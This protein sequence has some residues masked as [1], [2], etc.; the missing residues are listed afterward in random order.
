MS[1]SLAPYEAV[2]LGVSSDL[3]R[4][5]SAIAMAVRAHGDQRYGPN[6]YKVHLLEVLS[7]GFEFGVTDAPVLTAAPLHDAIEDTDLS[8]AKIEAAFGTRVANIVDAVSD[9][10]GYKNRKERKAAAYPRIAAVPGAVTLK[11]M[12]RI[13]NVRSC[14]REAQA[15]KAAKSLLGMYKKEHGGFRKAL[16][17]RVSPS[18]VAR[19]PFGPEAA[20]WDEI[21]RLVAWTP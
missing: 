21:D 4:V 2:P 3:A 13:A 19:E 18:G 5:Q 7:V 20:M 9:P 6:P 17:V 10:P 8:K 12:D 16:R 15:E 1:S 11:L 14:W